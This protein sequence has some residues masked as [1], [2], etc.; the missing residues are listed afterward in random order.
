MEVEEAEVATIMGP[1]ETITMREV[2]G[3]TE[4]MVS[5]TTTTMIRAGGIIR[6]EIGGMETLKGITMV[7]GRTDTRI[8]DSRI[9]RGPI[10]T[11]SST[12]ATR[13]NLPLDSSRPGREDRESTRRNGRRILGSILRK[14]K[15]RKSSSWKERSRL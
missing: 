1:G 9:G 11:I 15:L 6:G 12:K 8:G 2:P 4:G 5:T 10:S 7:G 3:T 13:R 14:K